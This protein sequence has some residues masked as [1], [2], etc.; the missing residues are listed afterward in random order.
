M[1][2]HIV[3][4]FSLMVSLLYADNQW[5]HY[6]DRTIASIK[7]IAGW[8]SDD[9]AF[10]IMDIIKNHQPQL[11]VEIGVFAG[12]SLY[13]IAKAIQYNRSGKVLAIDAWNS[14][15]ATQGFA[16]TDPNYA[17]WN[18][19]NYNQFYYNTLSLINQSN[20]AQYCTLIKKSS[21]E[22]LELFADESIDFIHFDGNHNAE[23][24]FW[25][26]YNYFPKVKDSGYILLNDPN[27]ASM[28]RSLTFLLERAD[29]VSSFSR[30]ASL[31]LLRK[32]KERMQKAAFLF[33]D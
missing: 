11:C 33:K 8:C 22:A 4:G 10:L 3:C 28:T 18:Q 17:W 20:L 30:S 23:F 9:K 24:A 2:K 27:W 14:K 7:N 5:E 26:V 29:I 21:Q 12:K 25:D 31:L 13:P 15:I 32:N 1:L 16:R 19:L 6:K